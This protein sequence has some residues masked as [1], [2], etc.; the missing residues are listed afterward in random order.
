MNEGTYVHTYVCACISCVYISHVAQV[1]DTAQVTRQVSLLGIIAREQGR[2]LA[3]TF[4][5]Y[6]ICCIELCAYLQYI[7]SIIHHT[8]IQVSYILPRCAA[9]DKVLT[10]Y[11]RL[12]PQ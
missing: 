4:L 1:S 3:N 7:L 6:I 2:K 10:D 9:A 11:H 5:L 12:H 8:R